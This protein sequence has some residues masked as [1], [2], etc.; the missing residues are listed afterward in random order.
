MLQECV[1]VYQET[2]ARLNAASRYWFDKSYFCRLLNMSG[3]ETHVFMAM[4]EG[5]MGAFGFFTLC[6]GIVQYHLAGTRTKFL[7]FSPM[8]L[9][10]DEVR[11]WAVD[12]GARFLHLGG[13]VGGRQDSLFHF[14]AGFSDRRHAFVTWRWIL[15]P[16]RYAV[17][18]EA[19]RAVTGGGLDALTQ[20][21]FP[22][23]RAG[24]TA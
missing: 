24:L 14:K 19:R 2:M 18:C 20:G 22:A 4:Y 17:L 15:D 8:K 13:G 11:S 3:A 12:Q 5:E 6:N 1:S 7:R 21:Y 16:R 23:Y 10:L 9:L